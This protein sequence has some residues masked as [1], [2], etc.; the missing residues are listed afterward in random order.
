MTGQTV[1]APIRAAEYVRMST[2]HQN[3]SIRNQ[4]ATNLA[5]AACNGMQIV[6][7]YA[8]EGK[9]GLRFGHREGLKRLI[10]DAQRGAADYSAL[11]VYDV[12]RWGRYQNPDE[13]AHYEY[14]LARAGIRVH[15]CAEQFVNDGSPLSAI[16]K[17]IKRAMAGEYSRELSAKVFAGHLRLFKLGFRQGAA[18]AFGLRRLLVDQNCIAKGFLGRGEYKSIQTDRVV[19]VLG[20]LEEIKTVRWIFSAFVKQKKTEKQIVKILN[21]KSA[22]SGLDRP[23]TYHRIRGLLRNEIYIGTDVWNRRSAALGQKPVPNPQEAWLRWKCGFKPIIDPKLF[24]CAQEII[25]NR[26]LPLTDEQKLRPIKRLLRKHRFLSVRLIDEAPGLPSTTTYSKWFGGLRGLYRLVGFDDKMRP[27]SDEELLE[28]L[29]ALRKRKGNLSEDIINAAPGTPTSSTYRKRFGR[30]SEAYRLIGFAPRANSL[31][32]KSEATRLT[33]DEELLASLRKLLRDHGRL[34]AK[35]I[36]KSRR[37]PS[38]PTYCRRFGSL[39]RTY[40]LIGYSRQPSGRR[41]GHH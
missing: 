19:L 11:L 13:A 34:S 33:S 30:L 18:P 8:D 39:P 27:L 2:D 25:H 38:P 29:R 36:Q 20:P 6:R 32:G 40:E 31:R 21:A 16:V 7:T 23:W 17:A 14:I 24:A 1:S 28:R 3:Y 41:Q 4:S 12:S 9:S 35:I 10:D 5:Y 22:G 15:Y 26:S 37:V